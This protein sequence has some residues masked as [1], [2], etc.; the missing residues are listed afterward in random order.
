[1]VQY[2][3]EFDGLIDARN[4]RASLSLLHS[5]LEALIWTMESMR[6]LRQFHVTFATGC[7]QLV[8]M[9]LEPE[10]LLIFATYLEDIHLLKES[11]NY[12]AFIHVPRTEN[13][14]TYSLACSA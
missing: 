8:R 13:I 3:R 9:V 2:S 12:S 14:R 1:M 4:T 5:E 6:N 10:E 11:F 7:S